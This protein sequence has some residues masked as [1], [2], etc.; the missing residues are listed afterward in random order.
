MSTQGTIRISFVKQETLPI[1]YCVETPAPE[2]ANLKERQSEPLL[3]Y[4]VKSG[5][6]VP[7]VRKEKASVQSTIDG[8]PI[9]LDRYR[10]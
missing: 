5:P 9:S 7:M 6:L 3:Y 8:T 10:Y 1:S 2:Q 4:A